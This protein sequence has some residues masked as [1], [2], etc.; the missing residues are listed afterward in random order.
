M[1][2]RRVLL[3]GRWLAFAG[4]LAECCRIPT[5]TLDEEFKFLG[6]AIRLNQLGN[7]TLAEADRLAAVL[8]HHD[9]PLAVEAV[10]VVRERIQG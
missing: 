10:G 6:P 4:T 7:Q 1:R 2:L 8:R 9:L 3:V 5:P